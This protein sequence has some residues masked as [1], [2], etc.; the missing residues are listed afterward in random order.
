LVALDER[1]GP[2]TLIRPLGAGGMAETF[3]AER[4]GPGEFVQRV[5]L[6]RVR[7]DLGG[8]ADLVRQF[9]SEAAI[10]ARLRHA[11]IAQVLDFGEHDGELYMAIELID[12]LDLRQLLR[13]SPHGM[14]ASQVTLIAVELCTALSFA[15]GAAGG[16]VVHRDVSPSNV[17]VST[18]GEIKLADFGIARAIAEPSHT[19]TGIVRGKV[20]YMA[21]EY[22]RTARLD[23][24]ADLFSLGVLLYE[25]A[26]GSRPFVGVTDI[27][28]LELAARGEHVALSERAPE[29]PAALAAIIEQ[30]FEAE[31]ELRFDSAS[32]ALEALLSLPS[33]PRARRELGARVIVARQGEARE[34]ASSAPPPRSPSVTRTA[35]STPP[36]AG[37]ALAQTELASAALP[38]A[39]KRGPRIALA[40][41]LLVAALAVGLAIYLP[42]QTPEPVAE[43]PSVPTADKR[44]GPELVL[45]PEPARS[46]A[47]STTSQ[48]D[49]AIP[50]ATS[51]ASALTRLEVIVYPF[52]QVFIDDAAS[53]SSPVSVRLRPGVHTI[54]AETPQGTLRKRVT[55]RAGRPQRVTLE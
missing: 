1:V 11:S 27:E 15:H 44:P 5:C 32:A 13:H 45:R 14:P 10:A 26:C 21:P 4:R 28:T 8:S 25:C 33:D 42:G 38:A 49:A 31:P 30:L 2:Y 51:N 18:E 29:L 3:V 41:S 37:I 53:G 7:R 24:R 50:E 40:V 6:K 47:P 54:R 48:P 22:A 35:P 43:T 17:L 39:R 55:L 52:G 9:M 12:G 16:P 36:S 34:R 46:T 19:S 20:P 23:P